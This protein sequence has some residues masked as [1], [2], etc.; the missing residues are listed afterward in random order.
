MATSVVLEVLRFQSVTWES[1]RI[2][3]FQW[4]TPVR[5]PHT[6]SWSRR[7]SWPCHAQ[8]PIAM[9]WRNTV[10]DV[11]AG[12]CCTHTHLTDK[13]Y[14]WSREFASLPRAWEGFPD[15]QAA[16]SEITSH[17]WSSFAYLNRGARCVQKPC[18]QANLYST[19][20]PKLLQ[21]T[22]ETRHE[23]GSTSWEGET[24]NKKD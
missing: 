17:F 8:S 18:A 2:P 24:V 1:A 6:P 22:G 15:A 23:G 4:S 9:L 11:G 19:F 14:L 3:A 7:L 10:T 13:I 21:R 20:Q 5:N 16:K 12:S